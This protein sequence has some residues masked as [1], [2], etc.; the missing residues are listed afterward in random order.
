[1]DEIVEAALR[2]ADDLSEAFAAFDNINKTFIAQISIM[3]RLQAK[4]VLKALFLL[5]LEGEGTTAAEIGAAGVHQ[6][7]L[8]I[9]LRH[10]HGHVPCAPHE[11]LVR[12]AEGEFRGDRTDL[13]PVGVIGATL[14]QLVVEPDDVLAVVRGGEPEVTVRA[15]GVVFAAVGKRTLAAFEPPDRAGTSG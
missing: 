8:S 13:D 3:Q 6:D 11:R 5:S 2:K 1:M 12:H 10:G 9:P 7:G 15:D 4:L 14:L